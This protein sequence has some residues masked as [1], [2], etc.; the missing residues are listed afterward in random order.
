MSDRGFLLID[1]PAGMTSH[2]VVARVRRAINIRK[3]GHAGTLDPLATGLL[4]CGV[5]PATKLMRFVQDL[6]KE[7]VGQIQ[8]GVATDSLDADGEETYRRPMLVTE[9]DLDA[10]IGQFT[11]TVYQ[12]PPMVSALKVGGRRLHE[13]ARQGIEVEREA[14]P[15]EIYSLQVLD[16]RPQEYSEAV[17]RV[18]CAKGTYVRVLADDL[19]KALGGRAHLKA[20]R[21][22]K[23][24]SLSVEHA[25]TLERLDALGEAGRWDTA[26]LSPFDTLA[27]LPHCLLRSEVADRVRHGARLAVEEVPGQW[28][29]GDIVRLADT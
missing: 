4:V 21:R 13:L 19:A 5:G 14:R 27:S 11:G 29:E 12:V 1:K 7:Y 28:T 18:V 26:L 6:P 17:I 24:G 25:V 15:V 8:F 9:A 22:L 16:V 20:L 10:L 23:T 2:D 3:V